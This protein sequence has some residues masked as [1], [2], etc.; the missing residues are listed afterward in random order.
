MRTLSPL[1]AA[2]SLAAMLPAQSAWSLITPSTTTNPAGVASLTGATDGTGLYVFGGRLGS[3]AVFGNGLN[4]SQ[5]LWR[6]DGLGWTNL[7]SPTGNPARREFFAIEW[8]P[9]TGR[10]VLFGGKDP[11]GGNLGDTWLWDQANGWVQLTLPVAPSARHW[12]SMVYDDTVGRLVLFGGYDG[13]SY[14]NDTWT[15]DGVAWQLQTPATSPS[16]RGRHGMAF[17]S[18]RSRVVLFGGTNASPNPNGET[19][20]WSSAASNWTRVTTATIPY[21]N[22]TR[23]GCVSPGMAYDSLR[24]RVVMVGGYDAVNTNTGGGGTTSDLY[25]D[26]TWEYDGTD[27]VDRGTFASL[28]GRG[29]PA[30]AFVPALG[31]T[32]LFGGFNDAYGGNAFPT[33]PMFPRIDNQ[34]YVYRT[35]TYAGFTENATLPGCPNVSGQPSISATALPWAGTTAA[36]RLTNIPGGSLPFVLFDFFTGSTNLALIGYPQCTVYLAAPTTFGAVPGGGSASWTLPIPDLPFLYGG[37]FYLQ[38]GALTGLAISLT[39]RGDGVFGAL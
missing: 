4:L 39:G 27:W 11:A 38:G 3:P 20:E 5:E 22:T 34:T 9:P 16:G 6:F 25:E 23:Q 17:D 7:T 37:S 14:F 36:F 21:D 15:F 12:C 29:G 2:L 13:T 10:L 35:T 18:F 24:R 8:F 33:N 31:A 1:A 30:C 19:W 28:P 32:I 26:N